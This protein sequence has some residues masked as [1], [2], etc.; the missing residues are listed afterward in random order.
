MLQNILQFAQS[1]TNEHLA[2][3]CSIVSSP[4]ILRCQYMT[5]GISM[6]T[7]SSPL[8]IK[9]QSIISS[10]LVYDI[11]CHNLN[12]L[13]FRKLLVLTNSIM[14]IFEILSPNRYLL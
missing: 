12:T 7:L 10:F 8:Q 11:K 6:L 4:C 1:V 14:L 3:V 13:Y 9:T 2:F 5:I